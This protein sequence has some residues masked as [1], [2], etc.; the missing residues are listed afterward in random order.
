MK[1]REPVAEVVKE[2]DTRAVDWTLPTEMVPVPVDGEVAK[3]M[4]SLNEVACQHFIQSVSTTIG[5]P[6]RAQVSSGDYHRT[7]VGYTTGYNGC[8]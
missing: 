4:P 1:V 3:N 7:S 5:I 8:Y 6:Y 2:Y